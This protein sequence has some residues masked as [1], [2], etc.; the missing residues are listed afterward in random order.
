MSLTRKQYTSLLADLEKKI[1][2]T[3]IHL[4]R[5]KDQRRVSEFFAELQEIESG[6]LFV[7]GQEDSIFSLIASSPT[8]FK[9]GNPTEYELQVTRR[10]GKLH[11]ATSSLQ[12]S[13]IT[14]SELERLT[15]NATWESAPADPSSD[16]EV[17]EVCKVKV[18][19]R[20]IA[21]AWTYAPETPIVSVANLAQIAPQPMTGS[22]VAFVP[23][24]SSGP[25][26]SIMPQQTFTTQFTVG[27]Q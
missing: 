13:F 18:M 8:F 27:K 14:E 3:E 10:N 2:Q 19:G 7:L 9:V 26:L 1:E 15:A 24:S 25:Q 21:R 11:I 17:D 12:R 6:Q 22:Q 20:D 16:H 4:Q 23:Q 5:L